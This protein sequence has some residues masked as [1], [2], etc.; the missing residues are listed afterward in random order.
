MPLVEHAGKFLI[1]DALKGYSEDF[2]LLSSENPYLFSLN[3]RTYSAHVSETHFAARANRDEWRIQVP[4]LVRDLQ[5]ERA[6]TGV[7]PVFLGYLAERG[8][9]FTGWE[10]A[11]VFSLR[12]EI[13]GSVYVPRSKVLLAASEIATIDVA[14]AGNLRRDTSKISFRPDFLGFYL[15]NLIPLHA[16]NDRHELEAAF[17]R[18][19][20][21]LETDEFSGRS[22]T[23]V[24]LGGERRLVTATRTSFARDPKFKFEVLNA[25]G[26]RCCV[27]ELQLGLVQAAHIIPHS[28]PAC[29]EVVTNGLALC[30]LHHK[31]YDDALLLPYSARRLI[32]NQEKVEHLQNIRQDSGIDQIRILASQRYRVPEHE[33]SRPNEG[34][35]E[36]GVRIRLGTEG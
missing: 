5:R 2:R 29:Q 24:E 16:A 25:Y 32:L 31:L 12:S 27:C 4:R 6:N 28:H 21:I 15:E 33:P 17:D 13:L 9:F 22:E 30:V 20:P 19:A 26:G 23:E 18:L 7:I 8:G 1:A 10:P 3:D 34:F 14:R 11:Y 36:R 35:L